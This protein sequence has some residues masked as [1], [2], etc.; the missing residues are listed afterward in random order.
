MKKGANKRLFYRGLEYTT[1]A[2]SLLQLGQFRFNALQIFQIL[3]EL[4]AAFLFLAQIRRPL[5]GQLFAALV[6]TG[7]A[8]RLLG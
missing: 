6:G 7:I 2:L 5:T 1:L 4:F 8:K 3:G